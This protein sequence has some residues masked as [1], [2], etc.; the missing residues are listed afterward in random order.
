MVKDWILDLVWFITVN[1]K[2]GGCESTTPWSTNEVYYQLINEHYQIIGQTKHIDDGPLMKA[3]DKSPNRQI[4]SNRTNEYKWDGFISSVMSFSLHLLRNSNI[5]CSI[6]FKQQLQ[7]VRIRQITIWL[8]GSLLQFAK[9]NHHA[10]K[11]IYFYGPFP[12]ANC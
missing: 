11:A 5:F 10:V 8:S 7:I 3:M 4:E 6:M 12:M 1:F 2:M 9:E